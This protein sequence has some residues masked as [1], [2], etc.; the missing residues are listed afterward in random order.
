[1]PSFLPLLATLL[2]VYP[3]PMF[4]PVVG[5]P[6]GWLLHVIFLYPVG[7]SHS[8]SLFH[9][10]SIGFFGFCL[11]VMLFDVFVFMLDYVISRHLNFGCCISLHYFGMLPAPKTAAAEM[12]VPNPRQPQQ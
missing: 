5:G 10:D 3:T 8:E 6:T 7:Y 2:T 12:H 11:I 1:M 9:L 4:F